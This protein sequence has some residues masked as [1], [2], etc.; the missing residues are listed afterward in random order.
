MKKPGEDDGNKG[1]SNKNNAL[2]L[3]DADDTAQQHSSS[4]SAMC[5]ESRPKPLLVQR[6]E[7]CRKL[8]LEYYKNDRLEEESIE[9]T[10]VA[11]EVAHWGEVAHTLRHFVRGLLDIL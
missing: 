7:V 3:I 9:K 11:H 10:C 5:E 1:S 6:H 8:A 4:S 2:L